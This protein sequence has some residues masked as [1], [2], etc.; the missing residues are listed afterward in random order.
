LAR[1]NQQRKAIEAFEWKCQ[2]LAVH[3]VPRPLFNTVWVHYDH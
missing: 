1:D 2:R 3:A